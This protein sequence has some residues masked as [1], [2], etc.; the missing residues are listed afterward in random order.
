MHLFIATPCYGGVVTKDFMLSVIALKD[1]LNERD[2]PHT[3]ATLAN[4]SLVTR[5]RN[6]LAASF[7]ADEEATHLLFAD[8]DLHFAPEAVL[9]LI[10]RGAPLL[11]ASYPRKTL[12]WQ[13]AFELAPH[14]RSPIDLEAAA[15]DVTVSV[16]I[17]G[18]LFPGEE[19]DRVVRDGFVRVPY[20][21]TGLMLVERRVFDAVAKEHPDL[22]YVDDEAPEGDQRR[23]A[24]FDTLI[25]P[26]TGR[27]LGEDFA[28]CHRW[29]ACGGEVWVD[30]E[31]RLGHVGSH[32]FAGDTARRID[33][34]ARRRRARDDAG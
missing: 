32:R 14:A 6:R 30:T 19:I 16:G 10:E 29:R 22:R 15:V 12:D 28:F 8:A 7:L 9:R 2:I 20:A 11:A 21:G 18:E 4:D 33:L 24:F 13:A 17:E 25:H 1:A 27:L 23:V 5:A 31:S 26:T 34:E 3:L